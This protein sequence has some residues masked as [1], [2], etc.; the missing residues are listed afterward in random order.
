MVEPEHPDLFI[1][2][3]CRLLSLSRSAFYY[4]PVGES[5]FNLALMRLIDEAFLAEVGKVSRIGN[6]P[7]GRWL[8][9][10]CVTHKADKGGAKPERPSLIIS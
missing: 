7:L 9:R 8:Q 3:Q 5:P 10:P 4:T 1:G 6:V 2:Q